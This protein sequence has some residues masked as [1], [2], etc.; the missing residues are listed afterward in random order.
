MTF[1]YPQVK[2]GFVTEHTAQIP[3]RY[4]GLLALLPASIVSGIVSGW[5]ST[6]STTAGIGAGGIVAAFFLAVSLFVI[7]PE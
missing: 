5:W 2:H 4:D 6:F 1:N 7:P 3:T